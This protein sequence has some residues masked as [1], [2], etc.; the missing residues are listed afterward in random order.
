MFSFDFTEIWYLVMYENDH[1]MRVLGEEEIRHIF[2][3]FGD[4]NFSEAPGLTFRGKL[5][6]KAILIETNHSHTLMN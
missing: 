6:S 2:L 1:N 3:G 5:I 4:P